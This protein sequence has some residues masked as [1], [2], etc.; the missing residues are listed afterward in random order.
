MSDIVTLYPTKDLP[1]SRTF[2]TVNDAIYGAICDIPGISDFFTPFQVANPQTYGECYF[3]LQKGD[4]IVKIYMTNSSGSYSVKN[5]NS[6]GSSGNTDYTLSVDI[7]IRYAVGIG[8]TTAVWLDN[9]S[10]NICI[11]CNNFEDKSFI[12]TSSSQSNVSCYCSNTNG[13]VQ[14]F[15]FVFNGN[16]KGSSAQFVASVYRYYGVD[17]KDIYTFD[18]GLTDLPWG[19]FMIGKAEFVRLFGNFALRIK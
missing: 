15:P 8:G 12:A 16:N 3:C 13:L 6:S 18:G 10:K 17:T 9:Y 2:K 4:S 7:P 1:V 19:K 14:N 11:A 5:N